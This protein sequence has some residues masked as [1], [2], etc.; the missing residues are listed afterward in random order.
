MKEKRK[1]EPNQES[2]NN[3]VQKKKNI[4]NSNIKTFAF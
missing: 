3:Q 4:M 1:K 2:K